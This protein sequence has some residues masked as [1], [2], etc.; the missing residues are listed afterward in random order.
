MGGHHVR[1][2]ARTALVVEPVE[3]H[4]HRQDR[5]EGGA[6][7][8]GEGPGPGLGEL[9]EAV[10]GAEAT[11]AVDN[12]PAILGSHGGGAC[13]RAPVP[14]AVHRVRQCTE[15]KVHGVGSAL[16]VGPATHGRFS[17]KARALYARSS[18]PVPHMVHG[19]S[20]APS[21]RC[22]RCGS[23]LCVALERAVAESESQRVEVVRDAL[24]LGGGPRRVPRRGAAGEGGASPELERVAAQLAEQHG[25]ADDQRVLRGAEAREVVGR[26]E[27]GDGGGRDDDEQ[28]RPG[29]DGHLWPH[30]GHQVSGAPR[31]RCTVWGGGTMCGPDD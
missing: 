5:Q 22:T 9:D 6:G 10:D 3:P 8:D 1:G 25:A 2:L 4:A 13:S 28:P 26:A 19:L 11:A 16:G 15:G 12:V 14:P 21:G 17:R 24:L 20:S 18:A 31:G 27:A 23:A 29:G 30:T 7:R